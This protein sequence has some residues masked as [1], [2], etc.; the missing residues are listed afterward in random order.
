MQ[1][2]TQAY[3]LPLAIIFVCFHKTH[4]VYSFPARMFQ[5]HW[6]NSNLK[7]R[8][9]GAMIFCDGGHCGQTWGGI[10]GI[11]SLTDLISF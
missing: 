3:F 2:F 8:F 6:K 1:K 11:K 5:L 10:F 7:T 4:D 9:W